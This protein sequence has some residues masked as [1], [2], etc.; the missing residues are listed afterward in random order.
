MPAPAN[1][2]AAT[3]DARAYSSVTDV[4]WQCEGGDCAKVVS[5]TCSKGFVRACACAWLG[6][7]RNVYIGPNPPLGGDG[8]RVQS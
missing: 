6:G 4:K 3:P 7:D 1:I 5:G 8:A 2:L